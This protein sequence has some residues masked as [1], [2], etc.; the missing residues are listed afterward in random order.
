MRFCERPFNS[1]YM[2][3]DGEVWPCSWMHCTIG[4]LYE[5]DLDEIWNSK[6]AQQARDSILDGSF[7]FCRKMSCPFLE[8]N[9][10]PDLTEEEFK[11]RSVVCEIPQFI[12]I[13][14]DRICNIACTTCRTSVY[15]PKDGEREKIDDALERLVPYV[16][17]AKTVN[18]NGQGE[19]LANPSYLKFLE[20]L[21]PENQDFQISFETNGILFDQKHWE[22]FAHLAK[23]NLKVN[24]TLNSI[25]KE[26]FRYLTGGFDQFEQLMDNL[27]FLSTLRK[28]GQIN[29]L[30]LAMVVQESNFWEIPDY[31]RTFS[32][33]EVFSVDK[34]TLRPIYRWFGLKDET[35]WFKNVLN[36]MH[37]YHKEYLKILADSCWNDPKVYDWGCHNIREAVPHPLKQEE[38]YRK[39]LSKIYHQEGLQPVEY[40]KKCVEKLGAKR[41]GFYGK[42]EFSLEFA[43]L[44]K[45]TGA[46]VFQLTWALEDCVGEFPKVAKQEFRADMADAMLIIDFFKG[47]YWFQDLPALGFKGKIL[48]VEEFI[49]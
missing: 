18:L 38:I 5:Q 28:K 8:R 12:N 32:S 47:G 35:Y 14:N 25:R 13:A 45:E 48:T 15:C 4:N 22:R 36:P 1:T 34:I 31:V 29:Q 3:P 20:K 26:V 19:F 11:E 23:F 24:V 16:N 43:K 37:P 46:E 27:K 7:A 10:L 39:L 33:S 21:R 9:D 30:S 17:K 6:E 40:L 42:N 49:N 41:I 2:A 44:L